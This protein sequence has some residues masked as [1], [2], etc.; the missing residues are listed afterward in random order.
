MAVW[1]PGVRRALQWVDRQPPGSS[2]PFAEC[3]DRQG[4]RG[5]F[6]PRRAGVIQACRPK[7]SCSRPALT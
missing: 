5:R 4:D 2:R 3:L 1:W 7:S 6:R